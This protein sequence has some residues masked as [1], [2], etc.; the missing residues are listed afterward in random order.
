[1]DGKLKTEISECDYI[2]LKSDLGSY[3]KIPKEGGKKLTQATQVKKQSVP[4]L[5]NSLSLYTDSR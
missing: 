3:N 1:M 4:C 2:Y 5:T